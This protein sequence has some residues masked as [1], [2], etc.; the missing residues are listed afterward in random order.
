MVRPLQL[1]NIAAGQAPDVPPLPH[2]RQLQPHARGGLY[3]NLD[4]DTRAFVALCRHWPLFPD[5]FWW[6]L[7]QLLKMIDPPLL[8][9]VRCRNEQNIF[10]HCAG[11]W[12][13]KQLSS[14]VHQRYSEPEPSRYSTPPKLL[15]S[16]NIN[17]RF[18]SMI[19]PRAR[20]WISL[21][22]FFQTIN[23]RNLSERKVISFDKGVTSAAAG[24][25]NL[26]AGLEHPQVVYNS[27]WLF[28]VTS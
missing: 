11:W 21:F 17:L 18:F 7:P 27:V 13:N 4:E 3:L 23:R 16:P 5:I 20:D 1:I 15:N 24:R 10:V 26:A 2:P 12:E 19:I 6:P 25:F 14:L 9:D 22:Q 8:E 28:F